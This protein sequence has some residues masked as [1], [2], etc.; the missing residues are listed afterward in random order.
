M[1]PEGNCD[2]GVFRPKAL[3]TAL[4][5]A[6]LLVACG[7]SADDML[8]SAKDYLNKNDPSAASIQL[9][10]ALQKDPDIAEARF[11]LGSL[12]LQQGDIASAVKE[13]E[14]ARKLGYDSE[15]LSARLAR[16]WVQAGQ[17]AT[18]LETYG[19]QTLTDPAQMQQLQAALGDAHLL[20]N[21][22]EAARERYRAALAIDGQD[23]IARMGIARLQAQ[24][25]ETVQALASVEQVLAVHPTA[26]DAH[27]LRAEL[28]AREGRLAE[29]FSALEAAVE[30]AP[31]NTGYHFALVSRLLQDDR[32]DEAVQRLDAMRKIAPKDA[33]A[34]YLTAFIALRQ[35]RD[36]EA[37]TEIENALRQVPDNPLVQLLAGNIYLRQGE[38]VL[39][40]QQLEK[41]VAVAPEHP[42][43]RQALAATLLAGG[44]AADA[45]GVLDPLLADGMG[46]PVAMT[47]AGQAS[48]LAGDFAGASRFFS[49]VV[50]AAPSD[51]AA[52]TRLAVARLSSGDQENALAD[53]EAAIRLDDA[54]G[55][56]EYALIL[57][58]MR[59]RNFE[60]AL[61]VHA[62][63]ER[64]QPD[65]PQTYNLKGG[66]FMAMED[67]PAAR[68]AFEKALQVQPGFLS[69][70][71]N[72]AR[73]DLAENQPERAS[74]RLEAV[75][76]V[77]PRAPEAY[78]LLAELKLR[79]GA[80]ADE[81]LAI[82]ERGAQASPDQAAARAAIVRLHLG[83][84]DFGRA[85]TVAQELAAALPNDPV[86]ITVLAQAQFA[87]GDREQALASFNRVVRMQ[88]D[89]PA[90]LVSLADAQRATGDRATAR[91]SL[92]RALNLQPDLLDAQRRLIGI[93]V[94]EQRFD[95]ALSIV[96]QVQKQRPGID[97]GYLMEGDVHLAAQ[98]WPKAVA[99]FE[100]AMQ[101]APQAGTLIK[102]HGAL[103]RAGRETEAVQQ[104]DEWLAQ[105]PEDAL[106][107]RYLAE[108][109]IGAGQLQQA[110]SLYRRLVELNAQDVVALNNLAWVAGE[111]DRADA[112]ALARRA[113]SVAPDNASVL[114]TLGMLLLKSGATEEALQHLQRAVNLAPQTGLLRLNLA[115]GYVAAGRK[116]DAAREL[117]L[118]I[119]ELPAGSPLHEQ[120]SALKK[121]L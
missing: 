29:V 13:L 1:Q 2:R 82:L 30:H 77:N 34:Q 120:A 108:R 78:L 44:R 105:Q 18:A 111:L 115:R 48:M 94:E 37:R 38:H 119:G 19:A 47:L 28:L 59:D 116:D 83:R 62:Q 100:R 15:Q 11:L 101:L 6:G 24:A 41:V 36:A 113:L 46:N 56:P 16:A 74:E 32:I 21:E 118:L 97:I 60:Q 117:E 31:R 68:A 39:A 88:P 109:A 93:A 14:R 5:C 73:L 69:A 67:L 53:L 87:S 95:D 4:L 54:S 81:A 12:Q 99:A 49:R 10:N 42:L 52:R 85:L 112:L 8:L 89:A 104:A 35:G 25:G 107:R 45:R 102:L 7:Q 63:L 121:S 57:T 76:G 43:A 84:R 72:L 71:V 33:A 92:Q 61:K 103:V 70:A 65:N 17:G 79:T 91:Q 106:V 9:R 27:A 75:I 3:L 114:D 51:P 86:A 110:E 50:D 90:P 64:K 23:R 55:Q 20:R 66:I 96:S 98:A 22:P 58:H 26:A 80:S 40:R